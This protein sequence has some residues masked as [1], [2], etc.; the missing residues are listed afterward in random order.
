MNVRNLVGSGD[1]IALFTMPFVVAGVIL[2]LA[3][4]SMFSVGALPAWLRVLSIALLVLGLAI[5]IWS[6]ALILRNVPRGRLIT[7]GPFA[8]VRHPL[9]TS[10][11]LLVLPWLG[12]L[13]DT[14]LGVLI[15]V[16][17]YLG[18]RMFAPAEEARPGPGHSARSGMSTT[19]T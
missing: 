17:L 6:V 3:N 1:R 4:P 19:A 18:A 12:L 13:L 15:G 11:G 8:W 14:W 10:V 7:G 5:W 2:A 16:A 9:Y